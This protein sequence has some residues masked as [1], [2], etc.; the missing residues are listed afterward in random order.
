M[1]SRGASLLLISIQLKTGYM[2]IS[3]G[4]GI[5]EDKETNQLVK[6]VRSFELL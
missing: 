3:C 2:R 4:G 5:A 6:Q 1:S